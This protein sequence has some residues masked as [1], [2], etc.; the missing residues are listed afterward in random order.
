MLYQTDFQQKT[1]SAAQLWALCDRNVMILWYRGFTFVNIYYNN[2]WVCYVITTSNRIHCINITRNNQQIVHA[3]KYKYVNGCAVKV[4]GPTGHGAPGCPT[5]DE[6]QPE[7]R[8]GRPP[9]GLSLSAG[10]LTLL[11]FH[12]GGW[13]F[14]EEVEPKYNE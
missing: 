6:P 10:T 1:I 8:V 12:M 3:Y 13:S 4:A 5:G 11:S 7:E 9:G 2:K 14:Q